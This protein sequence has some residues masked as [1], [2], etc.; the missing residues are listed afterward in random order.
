VHPAA[1]GHVFT[2]ED[3]WLG[4]YFAKHPEYEIL[5]RKSR[6]GRNPVVDART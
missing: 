5:N 4:P 1:L 3:G 6:L 2:H